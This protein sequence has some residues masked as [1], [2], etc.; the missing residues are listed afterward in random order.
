MSIEI[1]KFAP[2]QS[3]GQKVQHQIEQGHG[4]GQSYVKSGGSTPS[5]SQPRTKAEVVQAYLDAHPNLSPEERQPYEQK[6]EILGAS[7]QE[8]SSNSNVAESVDGLPKN[9]LGN[10]TQDYRQNAGLPNDDY[11]PPLDSNDDL[12]DS[13]SSKPLDSSD[14][15]SFENDRIRYVEDPKDLGDFT[16][17]LQGDYRQN[18]RIDSDVADLPEDV[19]HDIQD[20]QGDYGQN[21][22]GQQPSL[23]SNDDLANSS[24]SNPTDS[25]ANQS[26]N[27]QGDYGQDGMAFESTPMGES[28][29]DS[30]DVGDSCSDMV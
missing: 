28:E 6:L 12:A 8:K 9:T 1:P 23:D 20:L 17:E 29:M 19:T 2:N 26:P 25:I 10:E 24:D 15:Q 14:N 7:G 27:L 4:E 30:S 22:N 3:P 16:P 18:Q 21:A 5:Q 11:Q 13:S